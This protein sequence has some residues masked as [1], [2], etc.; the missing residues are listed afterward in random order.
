M[1]FSVS[2]KVILGGRIHADT[3]NKQHGRFLHFRC[4]RAQTIS[5]RWGVTCAL[6]HKVDLV[7]LGELSMD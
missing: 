1:K 4:T 6:V 3:K 5:P 7:R 2:C